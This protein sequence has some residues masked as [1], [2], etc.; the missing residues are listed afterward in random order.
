[1]R[2][3]KIAHVAFEEASGRMFP[4]RNTDKGRVE[5]DAIDDEALGGQKSCVLGG[6]TC[7][8][9][10]APAL[11]VEPA[12]QSAYS[13]SFAAIVLEGCVDE[14][15]QLR[16]RAEHLRASTPLR[17]LYLGISRERIGR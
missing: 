4:F 9:Q 10:D 5:I 2:E 16:G 8:V 11:R 1:M 3:V 7:H 17:R 13:R 14:V 6:A 12:Q 15:V